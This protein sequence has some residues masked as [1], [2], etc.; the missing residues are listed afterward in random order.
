MRDYRIYAV[1]FDDTLCKSVWPGTGEVNEKLAEFIRE[2]HANGDKIILWTC[3][4]GKLLDEA[5]Q[6]CK[7]N[8]IPIDAVNDNLPETVERWGVNSRK[9]H[10]DYYIDDKMFIS[11]KFPVPFSV[12]K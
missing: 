4:C 8:N 11:D 7:D 5:V 12:Y 2:K 10:V 1:D 9:V 6:W 3:R